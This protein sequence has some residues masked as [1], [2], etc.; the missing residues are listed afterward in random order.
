MVGIVDF[1]RG[2]KRQVHQSSVRRRGRNSGVGIERTVLVHLGATVSQ[3]LGAT[4]VIFPRTD[5]P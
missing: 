4:V 2:T 5:E 3:V 1:N